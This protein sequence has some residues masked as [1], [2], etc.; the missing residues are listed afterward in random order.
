MR[1]LSLER[2]FVWLTD[3]SIEAGF[4]RENTSKTWLARVARNCVAAS[5]IS[6]VVG[7]DERGGMG[8]APARS[9][10]MSAGQWPCQSA[11][12]CHRLKTEIPGAGNR[13]RVLDALKR[14]PASE[15]REV[16]RQA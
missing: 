15:L 9:G 11:T 7:M 16:L 12:G 8:R 10:R 2:I 14:Q 5:R 1:G 13:T 6:C 3:S 4:G